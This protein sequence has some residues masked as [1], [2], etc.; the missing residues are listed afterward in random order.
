MLDARPAER[1]PHCKAL[2]AVID[3]PP[4]DCDHC[5]N[6]GHLDTIHLAAVEV[7][8]EMVERAARALWIANWEEMTFMACRTE[9]WP[10]A[11]ENAQIYRDRARVALVA[12]LST[13]QPR[14]DD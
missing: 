2:V 12:A 8:D 14:E 11:I 3:D 10:D 7:T 6:G 4:R 13:F 5:E 1:C 9:A